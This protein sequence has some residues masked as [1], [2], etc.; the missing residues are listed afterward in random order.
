MNRYARAALRLLLVLVAV[1][2]GIAC[3]ED[4]GPRSLVTITR[5]ASP[6]WPDTLGGGIYV[7]DVA[8][9]GAD[10]IPGT[11]DDI[12]FEDPVLITVH[13]EP[14]SDLQVVSP[15]GPFS[16]VVIERYRIDYIIDGEEVA[17]IE[18]RLHLVVPTGQSVTGSLVLVSGLAKSTPP[19]RSLAGSGDELFATAKITLY[20]HEMTSNDDIQAEGSIQVH[21]ADWVD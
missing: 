8:D 12:I 2:C 17:P 5:L 13:N 4:E 19:L 21:F 14:A 3:S 9:A 15:G 1:F 6:E 20:G 11:A 7:S 16:S 18:S 10:Q